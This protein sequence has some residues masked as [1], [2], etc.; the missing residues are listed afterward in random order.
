MDTANYL[1]EGKTGDAIWSGVK[2]GLGIACF[3]PP[4]AGT[5]CQ[6]ASAGIA[7]YEMP[8]VKNFVNGA[9]KDTGEIVAKK[10][11][12]GASFVAETGKN[13]AGLGQSAAKF[14]GIG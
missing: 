4:P 7:I 5:V 11:V 8:A 13:L 12:E 14:L 3:L 10:A 9:V 1:S 6:V 2:T